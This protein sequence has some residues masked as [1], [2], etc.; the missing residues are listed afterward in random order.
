MSQIGG[1]RQDTWHIQNQGPGQE[2]A[3]EGFA[4]GH[5]RVS[6]KVRLGVS[7]FQV[8][9]LPEPCLLNGWDPAGMGVTKS[10][11]VGGR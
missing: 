7:C 5:Q 8:A 3:V 1:P 6:C 2:R 9:S 4:R 11:D 10:Y